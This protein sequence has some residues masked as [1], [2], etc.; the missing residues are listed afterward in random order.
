MRGRGEVKG[1]KVRV[2]G[3][4]GVTGRGYGEGNG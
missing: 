4:E 1:E 3:R 2:K